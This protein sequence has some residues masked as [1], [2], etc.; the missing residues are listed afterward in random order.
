MTPV[1][2]GSRR[3]V[4]RPAR[5][6][7]PGDST[8]D[9]QPYSAQDWTLI[10]VGSAVEVIPAAGPA[11]RGRVDAKTPDSTIVWVVSL[12]GTGRQMHGNREGVHLSAAEA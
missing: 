5:D 10:D 1:K 8:G 7:A 11:Y 9:F 6:G 2:S 4:R 3:R 12:D